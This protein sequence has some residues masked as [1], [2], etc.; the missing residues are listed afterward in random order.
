[1]DKQNESDGGSDPGDDSQYPL[2][3]LLKTLNLGTVEDG[4]KEAITDKNLLKQGLTADKKLSGSNFAKHVELDKG[5]PFFARFPA[6][7]ALIISSVGFKIRMPKS[8][9]F[10]K[11]GKVSQLFPKRAHV[12]K[13][14]GS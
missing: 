14:S 2:S 1:L 10:F 9:R 13:H 8:D 12:S 6:D 5:K 7:F 11:K 3:S 4:P